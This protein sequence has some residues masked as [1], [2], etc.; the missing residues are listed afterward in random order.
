MVIF[1]FQLY[2]GTMICMK[3]VPTGATPLQAGKVRNVQHLQA[4]VLV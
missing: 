2:D 1:I 4:H 3:W